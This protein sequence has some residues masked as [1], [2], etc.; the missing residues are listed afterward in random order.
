MDAS[1]KHIYFESSAPKSLCM[2]L[3]VEDLKLPTIG[4]L[5]KWGIKI[6]E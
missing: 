2:Q 1:R 4:K 6:R 3:F 5:K